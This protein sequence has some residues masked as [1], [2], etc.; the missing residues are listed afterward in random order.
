M[1]KLNAFF[2]KVFS[3]VMQLMIGVLVG[4]FGI[5]LI[6]V[7]D[8]TSVGL[9][10]I[11]TVLGLVG[12][13]ILGVMVHEL[14]HLVFGLATGYKFSLFRLFS[15]A[16]FKE[17]DKIKLT[18]SKNFALGQCVLAPAARFEDFK[19]ILYHL[20]GVLAQLLLCVLLFVF[21][22]LTPADSL[23][24]W[25]LLLA[26]FLNV[27]LALLNLI[28]IKSMEAPNDCA[29]IIEAL[30][31]KEATYALYMMFDVHHQM[32]N[33][34]IISDF[35]LETFR[36]SEHAD[37]KNYLVAYLLMLRV[38]WFVASDEY[39]KAL[40]ELLSLDLE[41]LP[42]YYRDVI[43]MDL[44]YF[45]TVYVP[46]YVKAKLLY[47]DK[48]LQAKWKVKLPSIFR[49]SA[50]YHY[51]ILEDKQATMSLLAAAKGAVTSL[52]NQG[53]KKMETAELEKLEQQMS[54]VVG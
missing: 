3:F 45:Y 42:N 23:F 16:W 1:K 28:P 46:D 48:R 8:D 19:F 24:R 27:C 2:K 20:G 31:S 25:I 9:I 51:F 39:E 40:A 6:A 17:E 13:F 22:M 49:I 32:M 43:M 26:I 21:A 37:L 52:P 50:A 14:G 35:E 33:G 44:V 34:K 11:V 41:K 18:I 53:E 30:K 29:N 54:G 7:P 38:S 15:F 10:F 4:W 12:S 47:E 5:G 36:L